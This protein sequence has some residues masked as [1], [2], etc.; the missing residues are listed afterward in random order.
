[1]GVVLE[2]TVLLLLVAILVA[3]VARRFR[4]PYTVGLVA[5]GVIL[6]VT[7]SGIELYLTHELILDV[8]LPPLL[9]EAAINLPPH[10]LRKD[11]FP[12]MVLA[13]CGVVIPALV[14]GGG[15]M[16]WLG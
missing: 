9:F 7:H 12:V 11:F 14:V 2:R 8:I 10:E 1:M 4:L 13:G 16:F 6:S 15:T 3:I 5:T